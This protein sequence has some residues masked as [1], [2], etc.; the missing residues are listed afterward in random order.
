MATKS[1]PILRADR[2]HGHSAPDRSHSRDN[3]MRNMTEGRKSRQSL[4][5][6]P[7][8]PKKQR[9]SPRSGARSNKP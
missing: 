5:N 7:A 3:P 4:T 2:I 1:M 9:K 6:P 8:D